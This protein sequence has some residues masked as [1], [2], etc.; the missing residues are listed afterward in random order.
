V[1]VTLAVRIEGVAASVRVGRGRIAIENGIHPESLVIVD[2][3]SE[4][5]LRLVTGSILRDLTSPVRRRT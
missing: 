2:G 4:P 5:L 3:G 1:P